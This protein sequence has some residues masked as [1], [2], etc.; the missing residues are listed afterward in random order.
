MSKAREN[1][2]VSALKKADYPMDMAFPS[3]FRLDFSLSLFF[4]VTCSAFP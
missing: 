4:A 1:S 3:Q 2:P